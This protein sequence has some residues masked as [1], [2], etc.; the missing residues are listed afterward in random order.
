MFIVYEINKKDNP[1]H[2]YIG[3]HNKVDDDYMGSGVNM[4]KA[5]KKYGRDAFEKKVLLICENEEYAYDIEE[6]LI[7]AK[8][9]YYNVST[10]GRHSASGMKH[11]EEAKRKMSEASKRYWANVSPEDLELRNKRLSDAMAGRPKPY[12]V[13]RN[14]KIKIKWTKERRE[15]H[16][17]LMSGSGNPMFGKKNHQSLNRPDVKTEDLIA[18]RN[19]GMMWTEIG[20]KYNMT[21]TGARMR[22]KSHQQRSMTNP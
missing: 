20:K 2:N 1:N 14:K 16:S 22:V 10:G 15:K 7:K 11:T 9:P 19:S 21:P 18:D 5:L 3:K 4:K 6:K 8:G 17:A 12:M 13:E